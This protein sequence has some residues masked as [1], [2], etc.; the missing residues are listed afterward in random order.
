LPEQ[1]VRDLALAG[2]LHDLGKSDPRFQAW[3][4]G[5]LD[6]ETVRVASRPLLAKSGMDPRDRRARRLARERAR[7]PA[8]GRHETLSVALVAGSPL[9]GQAHDPELVL[10]LIASHH[11]AARP[12]LPAVE[13]PDAPLV[14]LAWDGVRLQAPAAP[15]LERLDSGVGERFWRLVRR[16]GWWGLAYLEAILRLADWRQSEEEQATAGAGGGG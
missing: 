13:D 14:K 16:Y 15:G 12:F 5:D 4:Y 10:H 2:R 1:L 8:G 6:P 7:Y 3:L 11:G 9:M